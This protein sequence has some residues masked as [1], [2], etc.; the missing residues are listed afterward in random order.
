MQGAD[1]AKNRSLPQDLFAKVLGSKLGTAVDPS[2][3]KKMLA[4]GFGDD[5][6]NKALKAAGMLQ[7]QLD[8]MASGGG[9]H[10]KKAGMVSKVLGKCMGGVRALARWLAAFRAAR[11]CS[12]LAAMEVAA[13]QWSLLARQIA[14][15]AA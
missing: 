1:D 8:K 11:P 9:Q 13:S 6:S 14:R 10:A 3:V 12:A 7:G 15:T 4:K 5:A 2:S